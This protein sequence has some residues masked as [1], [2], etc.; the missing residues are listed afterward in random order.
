MSSSGLLQIFA[1]A[2]SLVPAATR[3]SERSWARNAM[4]ST[5]SSN[6]IEALG[7]KRFDLDQRLS[8]GHNFLLP[9]DTWRAGRALADEIRRIP[10]LKPAA[11]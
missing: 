7:R 10:R 6:L 9:Y 4:K 5:K 3:A 11:A 8:V 1:K 2:A